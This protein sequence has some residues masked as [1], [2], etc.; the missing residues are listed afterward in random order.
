MDS[1]A[2]DGMKSAEIQWMEEIL[3]HLI[4]GLSH[5]RVSTIQGGA[6]FRSPIHSISSPLCC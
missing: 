5:Y 1:A 4:G 3:H 6:G 2:D